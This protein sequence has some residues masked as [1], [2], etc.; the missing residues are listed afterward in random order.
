VAE[1]DRLLDRFCDREI[2]EILNGQGWRTW[3]DE[4]F[5]LKK[6]ADSFP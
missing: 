6:I 4:P 2:A 3:Q 5:N 1:I